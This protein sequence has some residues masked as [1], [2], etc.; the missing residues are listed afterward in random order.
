[1]SETWDAW[2]D[3]QRFCVICDS[4]RVRLAARGPCEEGGRLLEIHWLAI[5][6]AKST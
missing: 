1:M 2:L 5:D 6:A 4:E 3:H